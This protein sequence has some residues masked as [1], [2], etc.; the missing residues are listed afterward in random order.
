MRKLI[1]D[2]ETTGLS[3]AGNRVFCLGVLELFDEVPTG[4]SWE[5]FFKIPIPVGQVSEKITGITDDF[6]RDK[7]KFS[8]M[9]DEILEL[10]GDSPLIAH[11]AQ[12][13]INFINQ[14]LS[15]VSRPPLKN[16]VTCTLKLARKLFPNGSNSLDALCKRFK[17]DAGHRKFHSGLLDSE[18]LAKVY[19]NLIFQQ[20]DI[21]LE[22][23]V[24]SVENF[25]NFPLREWP[26]HS[27]FSEHLAF[28][29]KYSIKDPVAPAA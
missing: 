21:G 12:F 18:L 9:V 24:V 13:D 28:L 14:E 8:E 6:L 20:I 16:S 10:L 7:P 11:N 4:N 27:D 17:I 19:Y 22:E 29:A 2:T 3:L 25:M 1:I 23:E 5:Y 15:L 26:Q